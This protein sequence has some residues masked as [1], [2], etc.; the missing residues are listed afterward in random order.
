MARAHACIRLDV[1]PGLWGLPRA[2]PTLLPCALQNPGLRPLASHTQVHLHAQACR[3]P[4]CRT[5]SPSSPRSSQTH[6]H[7]DMQHDPL[8]DMNLAKARHCNLPVHSTSRPTPS[9]KP[10]SSALCCSHSARS[11]MATAS[12][13]PYASLCSCRATCE[14][15]SA[16][17]TESSGRKAWK[18]GVGWQVTGVHSGGAKWAAMLSGDPVGGFAL[19]RAAGCASA[20]CRAEGCGVS[21]HHQVQRRLGFPLQ[22]SSAAGLVS[23][24][25]VCMARHASGSEGLVACGVAERAVGL[26]CALAAETEGPARLNQ[27]GW[28]WQQGH[29]HIR[30][31]SRA[32][33]APP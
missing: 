5:P 30:Y 24:T 17:I 15:A 20:G 9:P 23:H 3:R 2:F 7:C 19:G 32:V 29:A 31:Y 25:H 8:C 33:T 14:P 6:Q 16:L 22:G 11:A 28:I 1:K 26:R 27:R 12:R 4:A 10:T 13:L 18:V 21:G